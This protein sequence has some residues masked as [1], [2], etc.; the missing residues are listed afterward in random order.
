MSNTLILD[1]TTIKTD[2]DGRFCL[3]DLHKAAGGEPKH[4]PAFWMRNAQT[5]ELIAEIGASA[6]MQTPTATLNDGLNNG[7]YVCKEL[8]YAYAMS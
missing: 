3:N 5:R 7:T 4:Q 8:V 2:S 1:N 6:N